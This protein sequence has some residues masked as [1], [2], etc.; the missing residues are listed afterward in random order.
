MTP[1]GIEDLGGSKFEIL[2]YDNNKPGTTQAI[3]VDTKAE[4]WRYQV[5]I[6]PSQPNGI[7][8]GQGAAN[9]SMSSRCPPSSTRQPCPFCG[10]RA[11]PGPTRSRSA[12]T[13]PGTPTC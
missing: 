6:N 5:A 3:Q 10:P 2:I 11:R 13:R 1:I 4:T 8:S 9:E 12:A 7:W